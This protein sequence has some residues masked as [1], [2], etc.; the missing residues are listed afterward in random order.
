MTILTYADITGQTLNPC[1][2]RK[3]F[4][5]D[6]YIDAVERRGSADSVR[7]SLG[8]LWLL[9]QTLTLAGTDTSSLRLERDGN[10]RP[11]AVGHSELDFNLSHSGRYAVCAV[12]LGKEARVGVDVEERPD[13]IR[14]R[15]IA[16]RFFSDAEREI[17][18]ANGV[19][20]FCEVWTKK[21]ALIKYLGKTEKDL[22]ELDTVDRT[23][24]RFDIY[25][26]G[27]CVITLCRSKNSD[28]APEIKEIV[29]KTS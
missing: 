5:S 23:D 4:D 24:V 27:N 9:S 2:L 19:A 13:V 7:Q 17:F 29:I 12:M 11:Y 25:K 28:A 16:E 14:C 21:E 6:A 3:A 1:L 22:R 15:R 8:A 26:V 10:G 18:R 20:G